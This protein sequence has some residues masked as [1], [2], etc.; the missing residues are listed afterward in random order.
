MKHISYGVYSITCLVNGKKYYGS[1]KNVVSRLA[2][3]RSQ[4][5]SGLH[6]NRQLRSDS[7]S[8]GESAFTFKVLAMGDKIYCQKLENELMQIDNTLDS[9]YGYNRSCC[10]KWSDEAHQTNHEY[11]LIRSGKF[12]LIKENSLYHPMNPIYLESCLRGYET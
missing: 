4:F 12:K 8:Y 11:K 6:L 3:H 10:G 2:S 1:A 5:R 9:R 7:I